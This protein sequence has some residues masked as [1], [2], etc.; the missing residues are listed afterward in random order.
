M[1]DGALIPSNP[2]KLV[3]S[4][5][6]AKI[7]FIT[8]DCEDEGTLFSLST[9]NITTNAQFVEYIKTN[10]FPHITDE[11]MQSLAAAYPDDPTQ[12]SPFNTGTAN[13]ITPEFKRIAALQGDKTFQATRRFLLE[14][15]SKT[16]PTY[17]Y[18]Y[19]RGS[20]TPVLGAFHGSE[21]YD[22]FGFNNQT[23]WVATDAVI[24]FTRNLD[25]NPPADSI[26][27]LRNTKWPK[28]GSSA[29]YPPLLSFFDSA[30]TVNITSDTFRSDAI[31]LMIQLL[32]Q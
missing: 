24:Y 4:G 1:V 19:V 8:G 21:I 26:S 20:S 29:A 5:K 7:P 31:N 6:M 27:L 18:R 9:L 3:E 23:D 22:F 14:V 11:Q 13:A 30:P 15:A 16:Q 2:M 32:K 10:Y 12:G 17:S 25:P 28:W